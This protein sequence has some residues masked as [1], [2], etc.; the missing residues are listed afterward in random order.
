[1]AKIS[2]FI[3]S[4]FFALAKNQVLAAVRGMVGLS[5]KL[6]LLV[7][8]PTSSALPGWL[9]GSIKFPVGLAHT[10]CRVLLSSFNVSV[11]TARWRSPTTRVQRGDR[12]CRLCLVGIED[13]RHFMTCCP[14]FDGLR[15]DLT[16]DLCQLGFSSCI[17]LVHCLVR[18]LTAAHVPACL[19]FAKFFHKV[20]GHPVVA[21]ASSEITHRTPSLAISA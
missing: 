15:Q 2:C 19:L 18:C 8:V 21:K 10:V 13:I 9:S 6:D 4:E 17:D 1:M 16:D 5:P 11:E 3:Q 14:L 7:K 12:K 20:L